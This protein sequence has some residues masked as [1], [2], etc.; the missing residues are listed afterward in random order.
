[1]STGIGI[2]AS[3][4]FRQVPLGGPSNVY[5]DIDNS[6]SMEFDGVG[7][8]Y[9]AGNPSALDITGTLTISFWVYG[10]TN[11][12]LAGI[13]SKAPSTTSIV[14]NA[15]YHIEINGSSN[16]MRFVV[17]DVD[18]KAGDETTGTAPTLTVDQWQH[19]VMTWNGSTEMIVY[20]NGVEVATKVVSTKTISSNTESVRFGS[21]KGYNYLQGNMDEIAFWNVVLSPETILDMYNITASNPGKVANLTETP[22]GA[23]AAWY[24][25]GD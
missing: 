6:F 4:V 18:L 15:Q 1:M 22:E 21:R 12:S 20:K 14:T 10:K 13:I 9:D 23:P 11:V 17:T 25:M 16:G 3:Y 7:S 8:Y 24:R 19:F 2:G 5:T